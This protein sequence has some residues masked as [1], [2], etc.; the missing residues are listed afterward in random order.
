MA[1][2]T[3]VYCKCESS[4]QDTMYG[5]NKRLANVKGDKPDS[6]VARCTNC[7][8]EHSYKNVGKN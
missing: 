8:K 4:Y 3:V 1:R 6:S 5:S 2:T 7:G